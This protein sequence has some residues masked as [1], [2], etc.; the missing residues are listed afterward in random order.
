MNRAQEYFSFTPKLKN[1]FI[2]GMCIGFISFAAGLYFS[3]ERA[4]LN[5]VLNNFYFVS[6]AL[7]GA[8]IVALNGVT[9]SSWGAPYRR[10]AEA[11]TK[12]LP[13]GFIM[14]L[15]LFFGIHSIYEWSHA[16]I[17][18]KD[19][20]LQKK[21]PYLN[22]SFFMIRMVIYF[23]LWISI[24]KVMNAISD[25]RDQGGSLENTGKLVKWSAIFLVVFGFSYSMASYDWL[26]SL[27]PHWFSTI[28]AIYTFSG[29]F[30]S[31]I[32]LITLVAILLQNMGYLKGVI[33][34]DHYHDLGK[35]LF[36]FSTFWA[37]IWFSQYMLIWYSNIPEE[38]AYYYLR[39][40]HTWDWLFYF[41]LVINWLVPFFALMTRDSK[42]SKFILM[43]VS[44][45]LLV[46]HWLDLYLM[47]APKVLEH[48]H[49]H[50]SINWIEVGMAIG[51]V[52]LFG[53]VFAKSM[54]KRSLV[55]KNDP[56]LEEGIHLHQ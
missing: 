49:I 8:F 31:G 21:V 4:W 52:C 6:M 3:P 45:V 34:E 25:R 42:R 5:F 41:N 10:I 51:F 1:F 26:M 2:S 23:V 48:A 24:T 12:Y 18:A 15:V 38:T 7:A 11:M 44:I 37:Y 40:H 17:I 39:E 36:G 13:V 22:T 53:F 16:D 28:F 27:E 35:F 14:M 43:R 32:A 30:V 19:T 9:N 56:Y 33:T 20:L 46:G 55:Q 47:A 50:P 29:L 54:S